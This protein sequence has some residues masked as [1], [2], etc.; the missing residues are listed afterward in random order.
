MKTRTLRDRKLPPIPEEQTQEEQGIFN[1][2]LEIRGFRRSSL[3]SIK[4]K[5]KVLKTILFINIA[6]D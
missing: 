4:V 2:R 5:I 6:T 1:N 3:E